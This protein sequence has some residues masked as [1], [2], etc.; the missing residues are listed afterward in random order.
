MTTITINK[1]TKAG[2]I[3][4]ELAEILAAKDSSVTINENS[5][6][7]KIPNAKTLLA[8]KDAENRENLIPIK[9]KADFYKQMNS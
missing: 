1:R 6:N 5:K 8:M 9:D 2:K 4:F 3:L 7:T